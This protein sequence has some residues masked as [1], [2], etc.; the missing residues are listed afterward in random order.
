MDLKT[1]S[2]NVGLSV[3]SVRTPRA[4]CSF[5]F[6]SGFEHRER[7]RFRERMTP[8]RSF[9]TEII[10]YAGLF[11]PASLPMAA[12][13]ANYAE[14]L[15]GP[16]RDLLGRF[17]VPASRLVEFSGIARDLLPSHGYAKP[18]RLSV[19]VGDDVAADA[20][21]IL[22]F[23]A[24][25]GEGLQAGGATCDSVEMHARQPGDVQH[26]VTLFPPSLRLFFEITADADPAPLLHEIAAHKAAAKMR[27]GG[28]TEA[29]FPSSA[30]V[31]H[32]IA[33]CNSAGIPFKATAGLHHLIRSDYP[34]T[35]ESDS[36][37]ATMYGY[38]NLFLSA[39]L[40]RKGISEAEAREVLEEQNMGAIEVAD[41]AVSWRGHTLSANDL[42]ETRSRFAL[43]F[44]SCSF[45]EPVDEA[46]AL[47][48][49]KV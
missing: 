21:S 32:F 30:R 48:L 25:H 7:S 43:S 4:K 18:W 46:Y 38:L 6:E 14:Y 1:I 17:V 42:N 12:A 49:L 19:L 37:C 11:P 29:A 5:R 23:N 16:D 26:A 47:H 36:A 13:V 39:A 44:G 22:E 8:L 45:R 40:I 28:I 15:S 24:T 34:L 10:D 2:K 20:N 9:L 35:Y 41:D 27:T 31:I 3:T 33:A